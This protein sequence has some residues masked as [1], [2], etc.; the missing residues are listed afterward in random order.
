MAKEPKDELAEGERSDDSTEER[1]DDSTEEPSNDSTEEPSD[2]SAEEP[3]NDSAG[4]R[5][6]DSTEDSTGEP[7]DD[8]TEDS[9]GD[10]TDA[11][12]DSSGDRSKELA[13]GSFSD[14]PP[15][16]GDLKD[17]VIRTAREIGLQMRTVFGALGSWTG[18]QADSV[19]DKKRLS[20]LQLKLGQ[21]VFE[22]Q[23]V[24]ESELAEVRDAAD[25]S[26]KPQNPSTISL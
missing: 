2:D 12:G 10:S 8:S 4:E 1:S 17:R 22:K 13:L 14:P 9:A 18:K 6:D 26:P 16:Q 15:S 3:S 24:E 19:K 21:I 20:D 11:S 5:S 23:L 7:S 25:A